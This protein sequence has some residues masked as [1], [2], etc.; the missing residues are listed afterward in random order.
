MLIGMVR[1]IV[2]GWVK[3][4]ETHPRYGGLSD[5]RV[6]GILNHMLTSWGNEALL[7]DDRRLYTEAEIAVRR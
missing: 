6:A 5:E 4:E 1:V 3:Y 2:D 7:P